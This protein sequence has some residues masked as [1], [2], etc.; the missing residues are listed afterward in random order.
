MSLIFLA[1][2]EEARR[3]CAWGAPGPLQEGV[4]TDPGGEAGVE[5]SYRDLFPGPAPLSA[6]AEL[7]RLVDRGI[8]G[9][10][11]RDDAPGDA[12]VRLPRRKSRDR[13]RR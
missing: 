12:S 11:E 7:V 4:P 10:K 9:P 13:L 6:R 5:E 3:A 8:G 2:V 1:I